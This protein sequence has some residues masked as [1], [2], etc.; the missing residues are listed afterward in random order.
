MR[1]PC[2]RYVGAAAHGISNNTS[3]TSVHWQAPFDWH[4]CLHVSNKPGAAIC[5]HSHTL[6]LP[7]NQRAMTHESRPGL[8]ALHVTAK[9]YCNFSLVHMTSAHRMT[10]AAP[11]RPLFCC[12]HVPCMHDD[13]RRA[14]PFHLLQ[15]ASG[16]EGEFAVS[17][18]IF[19]QAAPVP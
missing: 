3:V 7:A 17:P 11:Q 14:Q 10:D 19:E 16:R 2:V 4:A 5:A 8:P 9:T 12:S 15:D 13:Q 1:C 18:P 6:R